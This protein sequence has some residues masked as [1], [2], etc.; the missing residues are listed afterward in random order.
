M[1]Q[2]HIVQS[3]SYGRI[4]S[5]LLSYCNSVRRSSGGEEMPS[6]HG[7]SANSFVDLQ[8]RLFAYSVNMLVQL[9]TLIKGIPSVEE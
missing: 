2:Q 4:V 8:Y 5:D 9:D 6:I 1:L 3:I 7:S